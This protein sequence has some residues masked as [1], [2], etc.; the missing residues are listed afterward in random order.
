VI[1]STSHN[2]AS[3]TKG[4]ASNHSAFSFF[5]RGWSSI[6]Y[7]TQ[8][9]PECHY[10]SSAISSVF[11]YSPMQSQVALGNENLIDGERAS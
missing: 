9:T 5:H 8:T 6:Y 2:F 10:K 7:F 11:S 3:N 4:E 1:T